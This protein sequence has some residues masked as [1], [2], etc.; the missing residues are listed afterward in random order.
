MDK[1]KGNFL[2]AY[3]KDADYFAQSQYFS[4]ESD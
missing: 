4:K 2:Y 3:A 1:I